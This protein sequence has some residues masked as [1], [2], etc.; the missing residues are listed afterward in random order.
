MTVEEFI[1]KWDEILNN[2]PELGR[3]EIPDEG[4]ERFARDRDELL[5]EILNDIG[6]IEC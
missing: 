4:W 6:L 5:T 1:E 3:I 2:Y